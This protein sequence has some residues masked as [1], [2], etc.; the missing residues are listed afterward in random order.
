M[1]D[2]T[3]VAADEV[4]AMR[5]DIASISADHMSITKRLLAIE[6]V[7]EDF[8]REF[9]DYAKSQIDWTRQ[10]MVALDAHMDR[11]EQ[12]LGRQATETAYQLRELAVLDHGDIRYEIKALDDKI[13]Q[14]Q[15]KQQKIVKLNH[16][17]IWASVI[18]VGSLLL[19]M[20]TKHFLIVW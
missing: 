20:V 17:F 15:T 3:I 6:D 2:S 9:K 14:I 11:E 13:C 7:T 16:K 19:G 10:M 5:M 12:V 8:R 1:N 4:A 18:G